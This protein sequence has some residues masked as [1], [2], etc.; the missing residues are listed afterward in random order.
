MRAYVCVC[1]CVYEDEG[2]CMEIRDL[3][4]ST[5]HFFFFLRLIFLAGY[6][7]WLASHTDLPASALELNEFIMLGSFLV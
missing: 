2:V 7:G 3:V 5:F 6:A 1:S 4:Y